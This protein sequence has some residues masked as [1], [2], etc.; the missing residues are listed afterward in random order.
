MEI[1]RNYN[2]TKFGE[3]D[4]DEKSAYI[5]IGYGAKTLE[6]INK[7]LKDKFPK[8]S[9]PNLKLKLHSTDI[10]SFAFLFKQIN[11]DR[12]FSSRKN[13]NFLFNGKP[14]RSFYADEEHQK[15]QIIMCYYKDR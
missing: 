3:K 8:Y 4:I 2:S 7:E 14:V 1:I 12:K 6:I 15:K 13:Y 9:F 11:F 5:K 10:I